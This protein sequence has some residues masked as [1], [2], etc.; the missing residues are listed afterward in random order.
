MG[1][2]VASILA[3]SRSLDILSRPPKFSEY[4]GPDD[5]D[6]QAIFD[7]AQKF[8]SDANGTIEIPKYWKAVLGDICQLPSFPRATGDPTKYLECIRQAM[9]KD[10]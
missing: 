10:R 4:I 6:Q 8:D 5:L 1:R 3:S 9:T 7:R 2:R